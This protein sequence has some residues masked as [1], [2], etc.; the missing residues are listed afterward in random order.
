MSLQL[1]IVGL[2][3]SGKSTLFNALTRAGAAVAPYPFTT[4]DPNVGVAA[5]VDPRLTALA[6]MVKPERVVPAAIEFLDIAGL[7]R[8]AHRGEGLGNRFL[9]HIRNVDAVVMVVRCFEDADVPHIYGRIDP[10]EDL[11]ILNLELVLADLS[12]VERRIDKI[13][14]AAKAAPREHATELAALE[15]LRIALQ[16]G[17]PAA[18][19]AREENGSEWVGEWTLLTGKP[20][21]LVANVSE[22]DLPTGGRAAELVL[23]R[24]SAEGAEAIVIC[25]QT[26]ADLLDWPEDEAA[27]YLKELGVPVR[28]L[29]QLVAASFRL[30]NLITFFTIT[31]GQEARSWPIP[32]D[33]PAPIAA[34]KIHTDMERGFIR[35]EVIEVDNLLKGGSWAAA[36]TAGQVRV[37]GRDYLVQD[38]D[39]IHFRFNV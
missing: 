18:Q 12:S 24:A 34:G 30:L 3:N 2:P 25:A 13:R 21:F 27:L 29:D 36:R 8:G 35:A 38:G 20:R 1:G 7:V 10:L 37:E 17:R 32:T 15:S 9:G 31:G 14:T 16:A 28:G 23:E 6:E 11:E 5:L 19:W 26:E 22:A 33:T 4:I 39:V